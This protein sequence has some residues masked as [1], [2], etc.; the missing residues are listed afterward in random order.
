[1]TKIQTSRQARQIGLNELAGANMGQRPDIIQLAGAVFYTPDD[2][3]WESDGQSLVPY[4]PEAG[5]GGLEGPGSSDF[6]LYAD[7]AYKV[8]QKV[9]GVWQDVQK[10]SLE[11][12]FLA[13]SVKT[14]L[15]TFHLGDSMDIKAGGQDVFFV[16]NV[17]GALW[18]PLW[19]GQSADGQAFYKPQAR[20]PNP[21]V[22]T[23]EPNGAMQAGKVYYGLRLTAPANTSYVK[24]ELVIAETYTGRL[25]YT[26]TAAPSGIMV[27]E[28]MVGAKDTV[29]TAGQTVTVP[30]LKFDLRTGDQVDVVIGKADGPNKGTAIEVRSGTT[31]TSRPYRKVYSR[32]FEDAEVVLAPKMPTITWG[33][34]PFSDFP[35][36]VYSTVA[37]SVNVNG[38][39]FTAAGAWTARIT[40]P[41]GLSVA[42]TSVGSTDLKGISGYGID[43]PQGEPSVASPHKLASV[44][45]PALELLDGNFVITSVVPITAIDFSSLKCAVSSAA[46]NNGKLQ[47]SFPAFSFAALKYFG[48]NLNLEN[49]NSTTIDFP[50]MTGFGGSLTLTRGAY[51]FPALKYIATNLTIGGTAAVPAAPM[52]SLIYIGYHRIYGNS[53]GVSDNVAVP[54]VGGGVSHGP[55]ATALTTV[56]TNGL[57]TVGE[58]IALATTS[59]LSCT[60]PNVTSYSIGSSVRFI[61]GN[62]AITGNKLTQASVDG[63]LASLVAL[64]GT[65]GKMMYGGARTVALNAG[66]NATPSATGLASKAT[67]VARG[68]T[69]THN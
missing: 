57:V 56:T 17:T 14:G 35:V 7:T 38:E 24:V 8:Q 19:Q 61:L 25:L 26:A 15:N 48:F 47:A 32:A 62:V 10:S 67:L 36:P 33:G 37:E 64:D 39:T 16:N 6:R 23:V 66:T 49:T 28:I 55:G 18:S 3:A 4:V 40:P 9:N 69:V 13:Q 34:L 58:N 30:F 1:M 5:G 22:D 31:D 42:I 45:F 27:A 44:L 60:A 65:G 11:G 53:L 59:A 21:T 51:T 52:P 63:I 41:G 50:V 2:K 68:V 12:S 29:W 43:L 20:V 46:T 54:R